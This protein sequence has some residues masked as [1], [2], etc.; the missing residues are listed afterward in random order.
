MKLDL[1]NKKRNFKKTPEPKGKLDNKQKFLFVIQKHAASHLHYDFRLEL[2]GVLLSWAVPKGPSL[3]PAVKRLAMHVEDHPVEYGHFEGIIPQGEYGGGTVMLW[4]Q[5]TWL[6]LDKDPQAAYRNGKLT[7]ILKAKKLKGQWHLIRFKKDDKKSWFLIKSKDKYA[8]PSHDYDITEAEPNSVLTGYDLEEIKD[9]TQKIWTRASGLEKFSK[10]SSHNTNLLKSIKI[11]LPKKSAPKSISPQLATLVDKAPE[12]N[13]WLHEL[14]FDG[15]RI[16]AYKSNSQI[17]LMSRNNKP[18]T[19][20]FDNIVAA[21]KKLPIKNVILDGEV[22]ILDKDGKSNFQLLQNAI[23]EKH[24]FKY[25]IFDLLYYDRYDLRK[26]PLIDRKHILKQIYDA[27]ESDILLYSN[28]IIG[29]GSQVFKNACE[30]ALEGIISKQIH[31]IYEEKRTKT[32]LKVKCTQRQE[33][34]I[35][36]YS[37]PQGARNHFGSLYLGYYDAKGNLKYCGNVGTGFDESSLKT[38]SSA[39][40]KL[41][42]RENPFTTHPPGITTAVWVKPELVA[43]VEF[44]EWTSGGTLR[45][46]SFKGLRTDK[47]A[48]KIT[49][50]YKTKTQTINSQ[51]KPAP[52]KLTHPDKILYP[53]GKIKK[54]DLAN[55]YDQIQEWILPYIANRPLTLVR[56]PEGYQS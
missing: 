21:L 52:Y 16:L 13:D 45:H 26:L 15:Y 20:H 2:D 40:K 31:S 5:G 49:R 10:N 35:G 51:K 17:Q 30:M 43:E 1:Y 27:T 8:K 53:E 46:P 24:P 23:G 37:P 4:D 48:R 44:S 12:G 54:M 7:F 19:Q 33:F 41:A 38:I 56:C 39:L 55:Y 29:S 50:E 25:Y 34:V 28:H 47:K 22:V 18:W 11:D 36:G 3:D 32:W 14:K 42:R 6:P 9:R